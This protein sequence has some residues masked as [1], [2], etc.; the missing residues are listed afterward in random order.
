M[1]EQ[2]SQTW[3]T[4]RRHI[5]EKRSIHTGAVLRPGAQERDADFARGYLEALNE[6]ENLAETPMPVTPPDTFEV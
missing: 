4:I 1:I 6:L 2:T 3:I 5:A